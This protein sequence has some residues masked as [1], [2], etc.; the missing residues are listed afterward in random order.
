MANGSHKLNCGSC[1]RWTRRFEVLARAFPSATV[2]KYA[3]DMGRVGA[4][5]VHILVAGFSCKDFSSMNSGRCGFDKEQGTTALTYR[6]CFSYVETERPEVV[7]YENVRM[8]KREHRLPR[9]PPI[10]E[11]Q[12]LWFRATAIAYMVRFLSVSL[13][14]RTS[15]AGVRG[16]V[17]FSM[18]RGIARRCSGHGKQC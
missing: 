18:L 2:Y 7:V 9:R 5:R 6:G 16:R 1:V 11:C 4:G 12:G 17:Q 14:S 8:T 10:V 3:E 15:G 13:G